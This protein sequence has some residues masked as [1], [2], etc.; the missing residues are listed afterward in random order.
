MIPIF[1]GVSAIVPSIL[2]LLYFR[3]RDVNREPTGVLL[4]VFGLGVLTVIPVLLVAW[5]LSL[6]GKGLAGPFALGAFGA[7]A[8][9]AI[10]EEFFKFVVVWFYASRHREFDEPM[11]GVVYGATASLGFATL[12]NVLYVGSGGLGVAILRAFTAVPGHAF[13]G[14]I[15]GYYVGR[16]RFT[17]AGQRGALVFYA[18]AIPTLLHGLYDFPL[19][20]L[21]AYETSGVKPDDAIA[22]VLVLGTLATLVFEWIYA[23]RLTRRMRR[24]QVALAEQAAAAA[25][26]AATAQPAAAMTQ[27]SGGAT[28]TFQPAAGFQPPPQAAEAAPA[29][30]APSFQPA[31]TMAAPPRAHA[32]PTSRG[33]LGWFL[34]ITGALLASVGGL[35]TLGVIASVAAGET[36]DADV[37]A[38]LLGGA[39]VGLLPLGFGLWMFIA[40][41]R[42]RVPMR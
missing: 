18:L 7:F 23:V 11:D 33:G 40:G 19:L 24:E 36:G 34:L 3:A 42:R 21:K 13:A 30:A 12:E 5:P 41:L 29:Q 35:M 15:M 10:P 38:M 20:T 17:P 37:G 39:I 31:P 1:A 25:P 6:V 28:P 27:P 32:A 22:A 4:K 9:A 14:A 16:A 26:A 8:T 2:L